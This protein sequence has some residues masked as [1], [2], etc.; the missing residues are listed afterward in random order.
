MGNACKSKATA[1]RIYGRI[2]KRFNKQ[3]EKRE[4]EDWIMDYRDFEDKVMK[5]LQEKLGS[6]YRVESGNLGTCC[7]PMGTASSLAGRE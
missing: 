4:Q 6:G 2:L 7:R 5:A 1:R 3:V